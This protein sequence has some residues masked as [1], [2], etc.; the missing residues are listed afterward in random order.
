MV[1]TFLVGPQLSIN[2]RVTID[3]GT[4]GSSRAFCI[5]QFAAMT[6]K[7]LASLLHEYCQSRPDWSVAYFDINPA[8]H[9]SDLESLRQLTSSEQR[10]AHPLYKTRLC[11]APVC[12]RG[13]ACPYA[14]NPSE[15]RAV[16]TDYTAPEYLFALT[17][18]R[19][20][21][22]QLE[23]CNLDSHP[24]KSE[25]KADLA[26]QGIRELH[27]K[28]DAARQHLVDDDSWA[29]V[30]AHALATSRQPSTTGSSHPPISP[31]KKRQLLEV[32]SRI[33]EIE[34][35][36]AA[37]LHGYERW[38]SCIG[39]TFGSMEPQLAATMRT[40]YGSFKEFVTVHA[41]QIR[42]QGSP[43]SAAGQDDET[44]LPVFYDALSAWISNRG[45]RV[46]AADV[47][48][49]YTEC[50]RFASAFRGKWKPSQHCD[51]DGQLRWLPNEAAPGAGWIEVLTMSP[52]TSHASSTGSP[53]AIGENEIDRRR[54]NALTSMGTDRTIEWLTS[55]QKSTVLQP[56]MAGLDEA[57]VHS[58]LGPAHPGVLAIIRAAGGT[59]IELTA[60]KMQIELGMRLHRSVKTARL[61]AYVN[62]LPAVFRVQEVT[63]MPGELRHRVFAVDANAPRDDATVWQHASRFTSLPPREAANTASSLD[64]W[65]EFLD[66]KGIDFQTARLM[67]VAEL[68][69]LGVAPDAAG[70]L[71]VVARLLG[72]G[73]ASNKDDM[74]VYAEYEQCEAE[75]TGDSTRGDIHQTLTT[76]REAEL[77]QQ[78]TEL[79]Q[80]CSNLQLRISVLEEARMCAICMERKRNTVIMP[81]MHAM[82]CSM[83]LR[84][85]HPVTSCPTC[86][87]PIAGLVDCRFDMVDEE[88]SDSFV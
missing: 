79:L 1:H 30:G 62:A 8:G 11:T 21:Q 7:S 44:D 23:F 50:P 55:A 2:Y 65:W 45:G 20:D 63:T 87:G 26:A 41:G 75:R 38:V 71:L 72:G 24:Q 59:G 22:P 56:A 76:S 5:P 77:Q 16:P 4:R 37:A 18:E 6:T 39:G 47:G 31:W 74:N 40:H 28:V 85:Q 64:P 46:S 83:C 73:G 9:A 33:N 35:V 51:R 66:S 15:L 36:R 82:F 57:T 17:L 84:G 49:F 34:A 42:V 53:S 19:P 25:A 32:V 61:A 80:R 67:S 43:A 12:P 3:V 88:Q 54:H 58:T 10:S 27:L 86:R 60:L 48:Q 52:P 78:V 68:V 69:G 81:C 13:D 14:H 70:R 29:V